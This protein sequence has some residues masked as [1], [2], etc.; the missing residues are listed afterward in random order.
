MTLRYVR[1]RG[2]GEDLSSRTASGLWP[3]P[4]AG[5]VGYWYAL[6]SLAFFAGA[7]GHIELSQP[8]IAVEG[9]GTLGKL[10]PISASLVV[11]AEWIF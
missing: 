1:A 4:S 2:F 5:P 9:A 11:G 3:A 10:E 6:K 7:T 8:E